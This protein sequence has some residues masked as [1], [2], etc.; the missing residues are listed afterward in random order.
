MKTPD[1][2]LYTDSSPNGFKIT[3]ALE[4]LGLPYVL[5]HVRIEQGEH[6]HPDFL[7]LNPHG[8]IPV[9]VD[10]DTGVTLFESAA[11]LMYLAEKT[12]RLLPDNLVMRWSAITWLMFHA[13]SMGPLLGQR[14]QYEIFDTSHSD[15]GERFRRLTE[16]AFTTLDNHLKDNFWLAGPEY[17]IADIATFG[18]MHIAHIIN[19]DFSRFSRLSAWHDRVSQRPAVQRG[20]NLPQPATGP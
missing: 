5:K 9:L 4:E 18:W 12:G 3:I 19:F 11:I 17:S 2:I 6:R 20:I 15:V 14:V 7:K 16:E 1:L 8:R 10:E 13:S